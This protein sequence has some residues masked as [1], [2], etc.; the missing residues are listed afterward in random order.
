[1]RTFFM[2]SKMKKISKIH[3]FFIVLSVFNNED[4]GDFL[5]KMTNTKKIEME[6]LWQYILKK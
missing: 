3:L 6:K 1:M 5:E 2:P 4:I